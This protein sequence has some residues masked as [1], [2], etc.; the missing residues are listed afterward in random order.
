MKV[1]VSITSLCEII[2]QERRKTKHKSGI[3]WSHKEDSFETPVGPPPTCVKKGLES[4]SESDHE[5][6]SFNTF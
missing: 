2:W 6:L 1:R 5:A 4:I 3:Q